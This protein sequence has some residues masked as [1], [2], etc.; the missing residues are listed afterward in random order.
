MLLSAASFT[1]NVLLVR[2][3][4]VMHAANIWLVTSVRFIVGL[5]IVLSFYR[6]EF[7]PRHLLRNRKLIERGVIGGF[8]VYLTYLTVVK[9]GAGRATF[10]GN[11]YVIW[12]ALLAAWMLR[13]K[14]GAAT[15]AGS[16]AALT[17]IGLLTNVFSMTAHPGI[18]D[19]LAMVAALL[20][21]YIVVIIRQLHATEHTATI[22][23]AQCIFGLL[24]CIVPSIMSYQP[25]SGNAWGIMLAAGITAGIGQLT[26]TR[27]F[28]D[29][30]VAE[31]SLIQML[32]PLGIAAGGMTFFG[33]RFTVHETV[34]AT[35]I[36]AGTAFTA[37]RNAN[38]A[39]LEVE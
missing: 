25:L 11:T 9:I 36:L 12:G 37:V 4:G 17:G 29:L 2:A 38:P 10:I 21:A 8:G 30:P 15:I 14:I 6:R 27:A 18:F 16:I 24:I 22:F 1:V 39:S 5:G 34:G 28:R 33:E 20:S 26:M 3:L 13:E 32:V 23:S 35:L 7:E 31:G 19:L